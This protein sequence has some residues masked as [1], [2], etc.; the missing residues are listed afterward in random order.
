MKQMLLQLKQKVSAE[1][2][3]E[4]AWGEEGRVDGCRVRIYAPPEV[5]TMSHCKSTANPTGSQRQTPPKVNSTLCSANIIASTNGFLLKKSPVRRA[6]VAL[7]TL[8][9]LTLSSR[10]KRLD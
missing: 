8:S 3:S 6:W 2:C 7:P 5:S 1:N 4:E 10:A 9:E